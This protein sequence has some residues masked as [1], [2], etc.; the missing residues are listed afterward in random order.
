VVAGGNPGNKL[1]KAR[2]LGVPVITEEEFER[3]LKT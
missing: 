2:Q 3:L 1:D